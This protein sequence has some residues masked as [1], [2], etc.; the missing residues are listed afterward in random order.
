MKGQ[1][2]KAVG[3]S[4]TVR[5]DGE[6]FKCSARGKLRL[7][8]DIYVGDFVE[9]ADGVLEAVL[10][11]RNKLLR[12]PVANIDIALIVVAPVPKPDFVLVDKVI[13]NC[14]NEGIRPVLCYNKCDLRSDRKVPLCF[15]TV[16]APNGYIPESMRPSVAETEHSPK[17]LLCHSEHSFLFDGYKKHFDCIEVSAKDRRGLEELKGIIADKLTCLLGQSAVGKT[18]ILNALWDVSVG[19]VGA[20]SKKIER[21]KNTTRHVEIF[22]HG[23]LKII[24]SC[25]FNML[26]PADIDYE[27]AAYYDEFVAVADNCKFKPCTHTAEPDCAV[28]AAVAAGTIDRGR[29]ERYLKIY[30]EYREK[31]K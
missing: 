6:D 27:I 14:Y 26:E 22:E 24:D 16:S 15:V 30:K 4:F 2:V 1:L 29:H 3:G 9:F 20:L 5:A 17:D 11:R 31:K 21:G 25:G 28:A 7:A 8:Q 10:P 19:E 13:L 23:K 18:S 12:P